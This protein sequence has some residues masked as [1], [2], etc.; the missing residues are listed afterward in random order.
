MKKQ[1]TFEEGCIVMK[2]IMIC[3]LFILMIGG[4]WFVST[5]I[6]KDS[7]AT[8][9]TITNTAKEESEEVVEGE[10]ITGLVRIYDVIPQGWE[11]TAYSVQEQVNAAQEGAWS[12]D[13]KEK[14]NAMA[15]L[16]LMEDVVFEQ[17][18]MRAGPFKGIKD[19]RTG[20]ATPYVSQLP[21]IIDACGYDIEYI[22]FDTWEE[23]H[24][25]LQ[26][27][28]GDGVTKLVLFNNSY[29]GSLIKEL[30]TG[31][32]ADLSRTLEDFDFYNAEKYD[33]SVLNA[34]MVDGR[35]VAIPLLYN[36][37][38]M[39]EGESK[40]VDSDMQITNLPNPIEGKNI[41]YMTFVEKLVTQ[42][43]SGNENKSVDYISAAL[44]EKTEPD[45]FLTAAGMDW[46]DYEK[47]KDVFELLLKYYQ[48]YNDT[49]IDGSGVTQQY[50]WAYY[51]NQAIYMENVSIG[52]E[53]TDDMVI[54]LELDGLEDT[55]HSVA[56]YRFPYHY[57]GNF[58][59]DSCVY[60]VE[61]S[62]AEEIV[63]HSMAG[64]LEAESHYVNGS[65][66]TGGGTM[67][68]WPI[69]T[70]YKEDKFAAQPNNYVAVIEEDGSLEQAVRVIE[71]MLA[72]ETY[73]YYGFSLNNETREKQLQDWIM[74]P[75]ASIKV[76]TLRFDEPSI[77]YEEG[78]ELPLLMGYAESSYDYSIRVF[79]GDLLRDQ[80]DN[81]DFAQIADREVLAI[82]Q[83]TLTEAVEKDLS[84]EAGFE[85]LCQRM[86][87]WY[88][89]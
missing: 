20:G 45:L 38:G 57:M 64:M 52:K 81:V 78:A 60:I 62:T 2:K 76:R 1:F 48:I 58:L 66:M 79:Y 30:Q 42:M 28:T 83:D 82:W 80:L 29:D 5:Q 72:S 35:Q 39:I 14:E 23:L 10:T 77:T 56:D 6:K 22:V 31:S 71:A 19:I 43:Q 44:E 25:E 75:S 73:I 4:I 88:G 26:N 3:L 40:K 16:N 32:Y 36:V 74:T 12:S 47:Q 27:S 7:N 13:S 50:R 89:K 53:M 54:D 21:R 85:L 37:S 24:Q 34:G 15:T 68:Y 18:M 17:H 46:E 11:Y 59:L 51:W 65:W 86:D 61:N 69:G 8:T 67:G 70:V 41:D 63:Y 55:V 9:N 33:Q 84:A 87:E 49:Q